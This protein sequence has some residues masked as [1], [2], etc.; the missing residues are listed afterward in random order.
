M[1][2]DLRIYLLVVP[3]L[4]GGLLFAAVGIAAAEPV[5]LPNISLN[6]GGGAPD[7]PAKAATVIQ[8]LF[9]LTVLSLAPA[10]LLMVTSFTRVV[11]VLSLLRH[12]LGT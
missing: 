1:K 5:P 2:K 12:A 6:I 11:V 7:S 10:I 3:L 4:I 9:I 8:L